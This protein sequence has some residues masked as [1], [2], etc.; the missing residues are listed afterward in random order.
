MVFLDFLSVF[1]KGYTRAVVGLQ[2]GRGARLG[3][4]WCHTGAVVGLH[5]G[6]GVAT[7]G[8]WWGHTGGVV[9]ATVRL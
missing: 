3:L 2:W 1:P 7:L 9:G 6:R 8:V 5:W 4:L